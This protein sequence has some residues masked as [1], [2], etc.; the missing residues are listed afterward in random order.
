MKKDQNNNLIFYYIGSVFALILFLYILTSHIDNGLYGYNRIA[1][2]QNNIVKY[3]LL[4]GLI[5]SAFIVSI[6]YYFFEASTIA[7][8]GMWKVG[9]LLLT[10][11]FCGILGKINCYYDESRG[12]IVETTLMTPVRKIYAREAIRRDSCVE[13]QNPSGKKER[14]SKLHFCFRKPSPKWNA[15]EVI[16]YAIPG[17]KVRLTVKEGY[18]GSKWIEG[19]RFD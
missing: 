5:S 3:A 1:E 18:F 11:S 15:E 12:K 7:I 2:N 16:S 19:I 14:Y 8:V 10:I 4:Y 6:L 9:F 13:I 17:R